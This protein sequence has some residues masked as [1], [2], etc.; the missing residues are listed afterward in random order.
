MQIFK[1]FPGEP[2]RGPPKSRFWNL[3]CLKLNLPEKNALEQV[4]KIGAS[5]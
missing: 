4:T 2:A 3:S 1:I 5:P